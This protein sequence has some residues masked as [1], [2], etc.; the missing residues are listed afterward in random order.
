MTAE[1]PAPIWLV[2]RLSPLD[3]GERSVLG[4]L[5]A[6]ARE[7]KARLVEILLEN[8]AYEVETPPGDAGPDESW[9]LEEDLRGRGL[10]PSAGRRIRAI[11]YG[12]FVQGLFGSE[13]VVQLP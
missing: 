1:P 7:R 5:A 2:V 4:A 11:S 6:L 8:A 13:K 12:E 10:V 3:P 9:V